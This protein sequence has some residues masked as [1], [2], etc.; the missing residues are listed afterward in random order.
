MG[1][2]AKSNFS[3]NCLLRKWRR[4]EREIVGV[5]VFVSVEVAWGDGGDLPRERRSLMAAE[6]RGALHDKGF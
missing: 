1:Q 4:E 2:S 3:R 5:P 6:K